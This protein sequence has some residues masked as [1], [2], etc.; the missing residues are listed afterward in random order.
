M[1]RRRAVRII[2]WIITIIAAIMIA[3][4]LYLKLYGKGIIE[5]KLSSVLG[6]PIKFESFSLD[7]NNYSVEFNE[8]RIPAKAG[9]KDK[10]LFRAD[11]LIVMLDKE[12]FRKERKVIFESITVANALLHI[13]RN[14]RGALNTAHNLPETR[15]GGLSFSDLEANAYAAIPKPNATLLYKFAKGVKKLA[16]RD[17]VIEFT[18]QHIYGVPYTLTCGNF[19]LTLTS[20]EM[21]DFMSLTGTL[22]FM[23][24][25]S[26]YTVEGKVLANVSMAVYEHV[27]NM[28]INVDTQHVDVMQFQPY[29]EQYTPFYFK[30]GLFSST[31]KLEMH[32]NVI[33]SLTTMAFHKLQLLLKP[34]MQNTQFLNENVNKL[35]PYLTS[36]SGDIIFDFTISGSPAS[37]QFGLGPKV[38]YAITMVAVEE[39]GKVLQQLQRLQK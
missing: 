26:R 39:V 25:A 29:F 10:D 24:P 20:G 3:I 5:N 2:V 36:G 23:I 13:E 4:F 6:R 15:S 22:A 17:S 38:K 14:K 35:V 27:A 7:L 16:I 18:D 28:E 8:F 37:P 1:K 19:N 11:Q 32:Q 9:F 34:G 31:T 30:E 12:K 33:R 21:P